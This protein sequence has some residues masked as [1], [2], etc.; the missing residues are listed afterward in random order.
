M[1]REHSV[2]TVLRDVTVGENTYK[3]KAQLQVTTVSWNECHG[4]GLNEPM[5]DVSYEV[6]E[7]SAFDKGG[8]EVLDEKLITKIEQQLL[9][10]L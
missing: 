3:V 8:H 2:E 6:Q 9:N 5:S 10:D 1:N 7:I 4:R